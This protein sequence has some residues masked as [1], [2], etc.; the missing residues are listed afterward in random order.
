MG[1]KTDGGAPIAI[2]KWITTPPEC[3][4]PQPLRAKERTIKHTADNQDPTDVDNPNGFQA[5]RK[6]A[7]DDSGHSY[8][9]DQLTPKIQS[10]LLREKPFIRF[11]L[12]ELAEYLEMDKLVPGKFVEFKKNEI[13]G[14]TWTDDALFKGKPY[15]I[16]NVSFNAV[17][18]TDLME[19]ERL[20]QFYHINVKVEAEAKE[21]L[22]VE[23]PYFKLRT[24]L[25]LSRG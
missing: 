11:L 1:K 15:R 13:T 4:L 16:V 20:K 7:F 2:P 17:I 19:V 23:R 9:P 10:K 18:N 21:E 22:Y 12:Q 14:E 5:V 24:F 8:F 3:Q 6:D 25:F